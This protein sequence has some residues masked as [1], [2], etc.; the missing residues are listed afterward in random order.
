MEN[1]LLICL[2]ELE[3]NLLNFKLPV[4]FFEGRNIYIFATNLRCL[5]RFGMSCRNHLK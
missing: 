4:F 1:D 5:A 2:R 3:T